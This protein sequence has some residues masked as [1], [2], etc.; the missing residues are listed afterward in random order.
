MAKPW[1]KYKSAPS[2]GP[3]A[4]YQSAPVDEQPTPPSDEPGMLETAGRF[5]LQGGSFGFIDEGVGAVKALAKKAFLN[6]TES[7]GELYRQGRDEY[8]ADDTAAA[9]ANPATAILAE[10]A[11]GMATGGLGNAAMKGLG[12]T[13]KAAISSGAYGLGKSNADLTKGEIGGAAM[14]TA[15]AAGGGA[16]TSKLLGAVGNKLKGATG[17]A[18]EL[19][20]KIVATPRELKIMSQQPGGVRAVGRTMIDEA[21]EPFQNAQGLASNLDDALVNKG[22]ALDEIRSL[23]PDIDGATILNQVADDVVTP[24]GQAGAP[25]RHLHGASRQ[26]LKALFNQDLSTPQV[27]ADGTVVRTPKPVPATRVQELKAGYR[28]GVNFDAQAAAQGGGRKSLM[29][30]P[31]EVRAKFASALEQA[32]EHNIEG[33]AG[34]AELSR[35]QQLKKVYGNLAQASSASKGQAARES[36]R[37]AIGPM[38]LGGGAMMGGV[39][40]KGLAGAV[41]FKQLRARGG[42]TAVW[43]LDKIGK[44]ANSPSMGKF[45]PML[46]K[47]GARSAAALTTTHYTLYNSSP[48]YRKALEAAEGDVE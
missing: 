41:A 4:K 12:T 34:P 22:T 42:T 27:L 26:E 15:I 43:T 13:A 38:E 35:Y 6:D 9:D 32:Q 33:S 11:G 45:A 37:M 23:G 5:G 30:A 48:E 40:L 8:R 16:L 10:L 1:E 44:A 3:W 28:K 25:S 18:E 21:I 14:D 36:S 2:A 24:Y 29:P 7:V 20:P 31:Q 19:A 46:Q 39:G 47:A 17:A